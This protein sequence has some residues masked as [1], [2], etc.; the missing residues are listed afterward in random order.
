MQTS[1]RFQEDVFSQTSLLFLLAEERKSDARCNGR[2]K[3]CFQ[4]EIS[5]SYKFNPGTYCSI[6]LWVKQC[7]FKVLKLRTTSFQK[8]ISGSYKFNPGL[9]PLVVPL[10]HWRTR[11][12]STKHNV[13][14]MMYNV[15]WLKSKKMLSKRSIGLSSV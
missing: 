4:K 1:L 3:R 9:L 5:G 11:A 7:N 10:F 15:R 6:A 14:S 13:H 2:V 8:E 12:D